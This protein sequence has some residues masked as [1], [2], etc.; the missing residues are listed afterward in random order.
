[1]ATHSSVL[2]WRIPGTGEPGGLPSMGCTESDTTEATSQQQQQ[3]QHTYLCTCMH[4][5]YFNLKSTHIY[6]FDLLIQIQGLLKKFLVGWL[7]SWLSFFQKGP[8]EVIFHFFKIEWE[9][10]GTCRATWRQI[11]YGVLPNLM[12]ILKMWLISI[13]KQSPSL[14]NRRTILFLHSQFQ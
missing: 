3:Q 6:W 7:E 12:T 5:C 4:I 9:F 10:T 13:L 2:A 11:S 8:P 14:Y 1:M